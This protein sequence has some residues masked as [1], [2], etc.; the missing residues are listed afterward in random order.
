MSLV[1]AFEKQGNFLFRYR[2]QFPVLLFLL[3]VPFLYW[4][5]AASLSDCSKDIYCYSAVILSVF[6]FFIAIPINI[7]KGKKI[8]NPVRAIIICSPSFSP[9]L[10]TFSLFI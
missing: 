6:G 1:N 8:I 9:L 5:D 10:F 2:G 4:T 7:I 3:A